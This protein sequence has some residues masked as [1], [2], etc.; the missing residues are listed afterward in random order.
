KNL[1]ATLA[2]PTGD[3]RLVG[4]LNGEI[5]AEQWIA[6]DALPH[7]LKLSVDDAELT[8][9]GIDMTRIIFQI[10]D[11]YDNVLPYA[12]SVIHFQV[13]GEADIIGENP[14]P[15]V[16]GQAAIYLKARYT[17]G[18]VTIRAKAS[19]IRLEAMEITVKL[20]AMNT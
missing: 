16:G 7:E 14:F 4:Y 17:P 11:K 9:D 13:E 8:A 6:A 10:V 5:A 1:G 19:P 12:I 2:Q 18:Q 15:L 3:L 20:S